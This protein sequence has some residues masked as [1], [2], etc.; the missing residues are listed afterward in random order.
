M[1]QFFEKYPKI[2]YTVMI[3]IFLVAWSLLSTGF[4]FFLILSQANFEA[5]GTR[6]V[7]I[8][9]FLISLFLVG[10]IPAL[11]EFGG[12]EFLG[13]KAQRKGFRILN[14]NIER[15][16]ISPDISTENLKA[17]FRSLV[18]CPIHTFNFCLRHG[19][20]IIIL[21]FFAEYLASEGSLTN[22][23]IIAVS[24]AV[25][26][27]LL[28]LFFLFFIQYFVSFSLKECRMFL[29]ERGIK[30]KE[31]ELKFSDINTKLNLSHTVPIFVALIIYFIFGLDMSIMIFITISLLMAA[32]ISRVLSFSISQTFK[33][34]GEFA[35][36][37]SLNKRVMFSTGSLSPEIVDLCS[38][39]NKAAEEV[40]SSR[41]KI[42]QSKR[43]LKQRVGEL[44][45]WRELIVGREAKMKE[46]TKEKK[47]IEKKIKND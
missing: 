18:D 30:I 21:V 10:E 19:T 45:K 23:S 26:L 4:G 12:L 14:E 6:D 39:L 25:S 22:F 36:E 41:V 13:M 3:L 40:Y 31:P 20:L 2:S 16:H 29:T 8:F 9:T 17:V 33:E 37:L 47:L 46:L 28:A 42:E 27:F 15:G 24:G 43:E 7:F 32:L 1:N 5:T 11:M 38:N 35:D 34:I 44:E